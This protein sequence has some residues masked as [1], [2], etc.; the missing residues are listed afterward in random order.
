MGGHRKPRMPRQPVVIY[1]ED[2]PDDVELIRMALARAGLRCALVA[3]GSRPEFEA[4]LEGEPPALILSDGSL[5]G[6]DGLSA[7]ALARARLPR[8]PF[9]VVSGALEPAAAEEYRRRGA[10]DCLLKDHRPA[11][12]EAVR[13]VLETAA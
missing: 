12:L 10:T 1:L 4:A 9:I 2:D 5:P 7:L 13:R 6:F 8:V 3:V 11:L